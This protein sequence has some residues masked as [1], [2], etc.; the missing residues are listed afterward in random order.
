M[1][2]ISIEGLPPRTAVMSFADAAF[3]YPTDI[4]V[5]E[6]YRPGRPCMRSDR[7]PDIDATII[8]L[9]L[10][11][12][13]RPHHREDA[14]ALP[15]RP[16]RAGET[17][18]HDLGRAPPSLNEE[19]NH[20]LHF[21]VT[22]E[23]LDLIAS[24]SN[25]QPIDRLDYEPGVPVDDAIIR[26]LGMAILP[27]LRDP[28]P[29]NSLFINCLTVALAAHVARTYGGLSP[30]PRHAR[31]GLAP[32]QINKARQLLGGN[33]SERIEL[34]EVAQACSLSISH[35]SRA[36]RESLGITPR[37]WLM[38]RRLDVAKRLIQHQDA[39]LAEIALSCGF[40]DQSHFTR[41]FT[42]ELAL[43][44]GCG[45]DLRNARRSFSP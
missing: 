45:G 22:R 19:P 29:S 3:L 41:V 27:R 20:Q 39:Q 36:F 10:L 31:G 25:A 17:M 28:S 4:A 37:K 35:F 38:K 11:D 8:S 18:F 1:T 24:E 13:P 33:L 14:R 42:R 32:W 9:Q 21:C 5:R 44:Q 7:V 6:Q 15:E 23:V 43:A 34:L 30:A 26:E 12:Q 40:A 16:I 2:A